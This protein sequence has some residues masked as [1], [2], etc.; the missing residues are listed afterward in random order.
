MATVFAKYMSYKKDNND[1]LHHVLQ[2]VVR[3]Q[4]KLA[5]EEEGEV[6]D[7]IT[8]DVSALISCLSYSKLQSSSLRPQLA[9]P[10]LCSSC[11]LLV[12]VI[13]RATSSL[14]FAPPPLC[15]SHRSSLAALFSFRGAAVWIAVL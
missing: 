1:L 11:H 6:G 5:E 2:Q 9:P 15:S 10:P 14:Q 12:G 4:I 8:F 7:E 3:D 13:A